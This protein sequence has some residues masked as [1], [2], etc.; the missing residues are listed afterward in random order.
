MWADYIKNINIK[1]DTEFKV[2]NEVSFYYG[3]KK[4]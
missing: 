4:I 1:K 3:I 2:V